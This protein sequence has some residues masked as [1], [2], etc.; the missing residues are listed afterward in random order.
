SPKRQRGRPSLALRAGNGPSI[1][2]H[3]RDHPRL[4]GDVL[5]LLAAL[6]PQ[7]DLP[8]RLRLPDQIDGLEEA[9][10]VRA[11]AL[12]KNVVLL[13]AGFL[14]RAVLQHVRDDEFIVV[15]LELD[16]DADES[17]QPLGPVALD[18][19]L[20][21]E[22]HKPPVRLALRLEFQG[23][24]L[25]AVSVLV[26]AYLERV[27]IDRVRSLVDLFLLAKVQVDTF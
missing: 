5:L 6:D 23:P 11:A 17:V 16:G 15:L 24:F 1:Q 21:L 8:P 25:G 4:D 2:Q 10:R 19:L 7:R 14:R 12:E 18:V 13:Q 27:L 26:D 9:R 22:D 20:T 3:E